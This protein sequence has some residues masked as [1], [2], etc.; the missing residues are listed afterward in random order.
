MDIEELV[1]DKI[2]SMIN[3]ALSRVIK[4]DIKLNK[5]TELDKEMIIKL[6]EAYG[7]EAIILDVDDT[8]RKN[9]RDI[10]D[11]NKKWI[12]NLRGELK[13]I[14]LS[15]GRDKKIEQF[16]K[17]RNIDYI[18]FAHKPLKRGFKKACEALDVSPEKVLVVGDSVIGDVH[19]G[20]RNKMKTA[21]VKRVDELDR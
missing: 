7:I 14:V 11:V 2:C 21:L 8:L 19:G 3:V 9:M 17:E 13:V 16:L 5:V 6:K 18:S 12:E 10:P 15:N 1:V 4:P 20:K